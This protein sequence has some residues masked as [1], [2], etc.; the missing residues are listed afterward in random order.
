MLKYRPNINPIKSIRLEAYQMSTMKKR[1]PMFLLALAMMVAMAVPA[2]ADGISTRASTDSFVTYCAYGGT[3]EMSTV[4]PSSMQ[5]GAEV[6]L[7][8]ASTS[9]THK[10]IAVKADDGSLRIFSRI[11]YS[12]GNKST[13]YTLNAYRVGSN[14]PCT[15]LKGSRDNRAD[16]E[17][18]FKTVDS[19]SFRI[20]LSKRNR[21]LFQNGINTTLTWQPYT[22]NNSCRWYEKF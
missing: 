14:W 21:Y 9:I 2:F 4:G 15:M 11:G 10:F 19:V 13:S 18:D 7:A 12:A 8:T 6:K 5:D 20:F 1:I 3:N 16:S 22:E 17:I